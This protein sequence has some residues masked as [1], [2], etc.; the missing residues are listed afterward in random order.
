M[1]W[2][3]VIPA[4]VI[5]FILQPTLCNIVSIK[6]IGPNPILCLLLVGVFLFPRE[7][8]CITCAVVVDALTLLLTGLMTV[9][10]KHYFN[11]ESKLS[12][13]PLAVIGTVVYYG[14]STLILFIGGM[15]MSFV[16]ILI[17]L[18]GLL[19][20]NIVIMYAMYF[21]MIR[22]ATARPRRSRYERYE[23]I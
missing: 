11:F 1:K 18:P 6:G 16:R 19:A 4:F 14:V 20:W 8:R 2:Y 17:S 7:N 5:A 13:L 22:K 23:I 21:I 10:Y 9:G 12:V 3:T 15:S